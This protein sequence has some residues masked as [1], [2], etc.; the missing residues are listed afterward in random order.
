M[1]NSAK[2]ALLL[3]CYMSCYAKAGE[4][5]SELVSKIK[6]YT[7]SEAAK[8]MDREEVF[9]KEEDSPSFNI[10]F[11]VL[12]K[13]YA[14]ACEQIAL[15]IPGYSES[16]NHEIEYTQNTFKKLRQVGKGV[17]SQ[18]YEGI[19]ALN[20]EKVAI[21][22]LKPIKEQKIRREAKILEAV[23]GGPNIIELIAVVK[24][25]ETEHSTFVMEFIDTPDKNLR[26]IKHKFSAEDVRYYMYQLLKAL[27]Y[28]NSKGV[29]HRDVK[30]ANIAIDHANHKL[31][32]LDW[33]NSE[34]YHPGQQFNP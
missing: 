7:S 17:F 16:S 28:A 33:G 1:I 32:L 5:A 19:N 8:K 9:V 23:K 12:P 3:L 30:P 25:P 21:K 13:Y 4:R 31:Y 11:N 18:V 26:K 10:T 15:E 27:D 6:V 29:M 22:V 20:D 34:F 2:S 24:D 14:H